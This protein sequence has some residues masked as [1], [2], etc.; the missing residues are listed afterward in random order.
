MSR[1]T[2][3]DWCGRTRDLPTGKL[4]AKCRALCDARVRKGAVKR[5]IK[6]KPLGKKVGGGSGIGII[7]ADGRRRVGDGQAV[8]RQRGSF[9]KK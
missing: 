5:F 7:Q 4:C 3:C 2:K 1:K 9:K 8:Y 6:K